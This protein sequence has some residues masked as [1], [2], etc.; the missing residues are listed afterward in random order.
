M[1][2]KKT[3][4]EGARKKRAPNGKRTQ[5]IMSFRIDNEVKHWLDIQENKG[6]YLNNLIWQDMIR[7][8]QKPSTD[9]PSQ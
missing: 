9:S 4:L 7:Q 2:E 3:V 8:S 5:S 1:S 6:R